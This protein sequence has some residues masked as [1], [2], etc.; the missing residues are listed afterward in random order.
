MCIRDRVSQQ[1]GHELLLLAIVCAIVCP[2]YLV[3]A[4]AYQPQRVFA[5]TPPK[6]ETDWSFYMSTTSTST[7]YNLGCNQG[8]FDA[9][10]SLPIDS[11]VVIDFGGEYDNSG[12]TQFIN[13]VTAT[14]SQIEAAAVSFAEG[15]WVCTG[16]G[17]GTS[18]IQLGIGTSNSWVG[19]IYSEEIGKYGD[20]PITTI[21]TFTAPTSATSLTITAVN[22]SAMTV[23]TNTGASLTF[24]LGANTFMSGS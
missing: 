19:A 3:V 4:I 14:V 1:F 18:V 15:Y 16:P 9:G 5:S 2:M 6:P 23:R 7:A 8:K 20:G 17:D 24:N 21:G 10:F 12:D 11:E 13:G 22:G